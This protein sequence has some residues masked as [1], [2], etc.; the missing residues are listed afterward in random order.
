MAVPGV[1]VKSYSM[2]RVQN[3]RERHN[4]AELEESALPCTTLFFLKFRIAAAQHYWCVCDNSSCLH[5]CMA[6]KG[7][8]RI[9]QRI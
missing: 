6:V 3:Q 5:G 8:M 4:N 7:G 1:E 9:E 2:R